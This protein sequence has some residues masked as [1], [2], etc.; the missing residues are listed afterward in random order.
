MFKKGDVIR[1]TIQASNDSWGL[2]DVSIGGAYPFRSVPSAHKRHQYFPGDVVV[3]GFL[4]TDAPVIISPGHRSSS[5]AI[6]TSRWAQVKYFSQNIGRT[7]F[8][9]TSE[10]GTAQLL[11]GDGEIYMELDPG[12]VPGY[13]DSTGTYMYT[14]M[15]RIN[16][17]GATHDATWD[18][19]GESHYSDIFHAGTSSYL[20]SSQSVFDQ[21][22]NVLRGVYYDSGTGLYHAVTVDYGV[23]YGNETITDHGSLSYSMMRPTTRHYAAV[24][25]L[26]GAYKLKYVT[27][28]GDETLIMGQKQSV[29]NQTYGPETICVILRD[30]NLNGSGSYDMGYNLDGEYTALDPVTMIPWVGYSTVYYG[31]DVWGGY[32]GSSWRMW[33]GDTP[34]FWKRVNVTGTANYDNYL[35]LETP[36]GEEQDCGSTFG[37]TTYPTYT[38][39]V[40][41]EDNEFE[42]ISS[43]VDLDSNHVRIKKYGKF[44]DLEKTFD[45]DM[46]DLHG[47]RGS[48]CQA[49]DRRFCRR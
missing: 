10:M 39:G 30:C 37:A 23:D 33:I 25:W 19:S 47:I 9:D 40:S 3:M 16:L 35:V 22:D 41:N 6:T 43:A 1:G 11:S 15:G 5:A 18:L 7:W 4:N 36:D 45:L 26:D 49:R 14:N 29:H 8:C 32:T 48:V 21:D 34:R 2:Y 46:T 42:I 12:E 17:S 24:T 31:S 38:N 20:C 27:W 44:Y 28:D 13:I